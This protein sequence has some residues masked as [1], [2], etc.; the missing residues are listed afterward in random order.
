LTQNDFNKILPSAVD[1]GLYMLG[2]SSKQAILFHDETFQPK[3]EN[4]SNMAK[5]KKTLARAEV[6]KYG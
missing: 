5:F 4:I 3:K 6:S 1:E 2:D